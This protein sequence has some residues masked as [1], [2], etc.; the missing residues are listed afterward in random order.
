MKKVNV[1]TSKMDKFAGK[2][3][4]IDPKKDRIVAVGETLKEISPLVT[5][6]VSDKRSAEAGPY[7][8]K[9]PRKDEGP[10]YAPSPLLTS[11]VAKKSQKIY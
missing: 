3:I 4:A 9:V 7:S 10:Y 5:Y 6:S 11:Q 1:P 8:F 2:W